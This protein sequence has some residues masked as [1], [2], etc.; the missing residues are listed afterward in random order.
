MMSDDVKVRKGMELLVM[1]Q[2]SA[3]HASA[4]CWAGKGRFG[5]FVCW[6]R[7]LSR[8]WRLGWVEMGG[9]CELTQ[10]KRCMAMPSARPI[11]I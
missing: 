4:V 5:C 2:T 7:G 6:R 8:G 1:A 10:L 9:R 3:V 11:V